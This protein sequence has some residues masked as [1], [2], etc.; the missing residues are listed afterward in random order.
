MLKLPSWAL[1]FAARSNMTEMNQVEQVMDAKNLFTYAG[2]AFFSRLYQLY[3]R[4]AYNSSFFQRQSWFGDF[5]IS[6]P[7][8]YM[9]SRA[10]D[11]N[12]NISAV[13]KLTFAA[14]SEEHG[15][16]APFLQSAD[17]EWPGA[18]NRTLAEILTT[19]WISFV[20]NH[21]PNPLR[22]A[23][24]PYWPSYVS[25]GSGTAANGEGVGFT[26]LAITYTTISPQRDPDAGAKCDFFGANGLAVRN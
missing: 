18:N 8:Y 13:F 17:I 5:I 4:S 3:P 26:N 12:S 19:Y 9:A 21:D 25:G 14:G 11:L 2:P 24:A 7:T 16:T 20:V 6:C 10:V 15:A 1:T 22:D 23:R